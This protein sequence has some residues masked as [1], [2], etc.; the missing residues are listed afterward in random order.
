MNRND[1]TVP[2]GVRRVWSSTSGDDSAPPIVLV[3]GSMDR[4]AGL[5]RLARRLRD[6]YY[7]IRYD[8]RG[9]ARSLAVGPPFAFDDQVADLVAVIEEYQVA[10]VALFGHS[11]GGNVALALADRRPDLVSAVA[12][13][14]S[15][16][17][18]LDW[19]PDGSPGGVALSTRSAGDAAEAFMRAVV[20]D[21]RWCDVHQRVRES[22]RLEGPAMVAELQDLRSRAPWAGDRI[23]A[24]VLA[25]HGEHAR[26]FH[27]RAMEELSRAVPD[28]RLVEIEGAGH[29]G[30]HTHADGTADALIRFLREHPDG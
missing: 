5:L 19:W 7:V 3:H 2:A 8:R 1:A 18:W 25:M 23:D 6:R 22:R 13:H 21:E 16:M 11:F 20:G 24:P 28:G 30:P 9:Y 12:V 10:P 4:S 29:T 14:E 17:S 27:R 15:P 26:L